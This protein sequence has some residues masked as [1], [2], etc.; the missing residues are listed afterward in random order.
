MRKIIF[1]GLAC[2]FIILTGLALTYERRPRPV[3]PPPNLMVLPANME[4]L[5]PAASI[6]DGPA[7]SRTSAP[8]AIEPAAAPG[9]AFNHQYAFRLPSNRIA[10]MQEAHAAACEKL[11]TRRCRIVGMRYSLTGDRDV[12][13]MLALKLDPA[14]SRQFGKD[15]IAAVTRTDG[16]LIESQ[17]S[18]ADAEAA[19]AAAGH[20]AVR[21]QA[22]IDRLDAGLRQ[23]G[24]SAT[25]RERLSNARSTARTALDRAHDDRDDGRESLAVTPM[26]FTYVSGMPLPDP[27]RPNTLGDSLATAKFT[28][29]KTVGMLIVIGSALLPG[30][31]LLL[32]GWLAWRGLRPH[33][34][35]WR[36]PVEPA[37][38]AA[39]PS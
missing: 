14:L 15:A 9:V 23:P 1:G 8:P 29:V 37:A 38:E 34:R 32:F 4:M 20:E 35:H 36:M 31:L 13:A 24:L 7:P 10:E 25:E 11:T 21:L 28:L 5:P 30:A 33:V 26:T 6:A 12:A 18:G 2:F 16:R 39:V 27:D 3:P 19:I 17:I 22:E